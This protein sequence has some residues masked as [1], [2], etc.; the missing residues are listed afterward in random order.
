MNTVHQVKKPFECTICDA[1]FTQKTSISAHM[2]SL[3]E[4]NKSFNCNNC[5]ACFAQNTSLNATFGIENKR[6]FK[7]ADSIPS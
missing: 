2:T 7:K 4:G 6:N 1:S 5:D 3:H